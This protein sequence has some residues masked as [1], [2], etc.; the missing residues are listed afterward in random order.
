VC[1]DQEEALAWR[2]TVPSLGPHKQIK[3]F[4]SWLTENTAH[5]VKQHY[6]DNQPTEQQ[7]IV[8]PREA[9]SAGSG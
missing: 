2:V 1:Y 5:F 9:G 7:P 3:L 4:L 8:F 6:P